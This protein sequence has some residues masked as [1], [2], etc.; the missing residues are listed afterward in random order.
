MSSAGP[1]EAAGAIRAP[2]KSRA[3]RDPRAAEQLA[4]RDPVAALPHDLEQLLLL[5][6]V[7]GILLRLRV[8]L[9]EVLLRHQ[10]LRD[11]DQRGRDQPEGRAQRQAEE[12]GACARCR[13]RR[14]AGTSPPPRPRRAT[15]RSPSTPPRR[16]TPAPGSPARAGDGQQAADDRDEAAHQGPRQ[17]ATARRNHPR[18]R[19][20]NLTSWPSPRSARR[21]RRARPR[22]RATRRCPPA[23]G[24]CA[25]VPKP[26]RSVGSL[27]ASM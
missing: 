10:P 19:P 15:G 5:L 2:A 8:V 23:P 25:R 22:R 7:L 27:L 17:H 14:S 1:S 12:L 20:K 24:R 6:A 26:P 3:R 18:I 21:R 13:A 9:R 11:D 16:P 4:A